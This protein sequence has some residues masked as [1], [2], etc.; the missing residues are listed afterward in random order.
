MN[1]IGV[2]NVRDPNAYKCCFCCHVKV[3]TILYGLVCLM[4]NIFAL[5]MVIL[6]SIHPD[7]LVP[8]NQQIDSIQGPQ[9]DGIKI[10]NA[11]EF[12]HMLQ[13]ARQVPHTITKEDVCMAYAITLISLMSAVAM[14]YGVIRHRPG[15]MIPFFCL[16]VFIF[17][18]SCLTLVSYF[19]YAPHFNVKVWIRDSG[20][21]KMPGMDKMMEIDSDYLM[22]FTVT[23]LILALCIKAY[24]IGMIWACYK[25]VQ[26]V[27]VAR[28]VTREYQVDPDT[29]MLLPPRY[30]DAI[31]TQS[32][33]APPPAYAQ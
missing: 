33:Q 11:D 31:K 21:A 24:L 23:M 26:Q 7:I 18:L 5:G 17:C 20:L 14:L 13:D 27:V 12:E 30:E 28:S 25:Y 10:T 8:T 9:F 32:A 1:K 4:F 2:M 19:T 3:G 16:H 6:M 29:E 15:Y 22:F